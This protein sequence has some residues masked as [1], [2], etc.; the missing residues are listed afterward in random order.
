MTTNNAQLSRDQYSELIGRLLY[1]ETQL[2]QFID[3]NSEFIQAL[4]QQLKDVPDDDDEIAQE[5]VQGL[6][7]LRKLYNETD[8]DIEILQRALKEEEVQ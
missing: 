4:H 3:P 6:R 2:E 1:L 8:N 7:Q 5:I